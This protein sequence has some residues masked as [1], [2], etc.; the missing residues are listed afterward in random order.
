MGGPPLEIQ[1]DEGGSLAVRG[2]VDPA[3]SGRFAES[4]MEAARGA[5]G[6]LVLDL[7]NLTF[8]DSSG[9][10]VLIEL[11]RDLGPGR[12]VILRAPQPGVLRLFEVAGIEELGSFR[13]ER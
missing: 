13:V 12:S 10:R 9:L 1:R 7:R 3:S 8:M 5:S 4:L 2:E 11:S 6:D